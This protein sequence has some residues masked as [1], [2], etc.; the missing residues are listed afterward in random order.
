MEIAGRR[1]RKIAACSLE[2]AKLRLIQFARM[3]FP[4]AHMTYVYNTNALIY[5]K[6][7]QT[8]QR[9]GDRAHIGGNRFLFQNTIR[10]IWKIPLLP[11][12]TGGVSI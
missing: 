10:R 8:Q 5:K 9:A 7:Y 3:R 2:V 11:Q 12:A 6:K 1:N 4:E